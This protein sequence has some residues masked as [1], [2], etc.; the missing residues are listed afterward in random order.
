[1]EKHGDIVPGQTPPEV[2]ACKNKVAAFKQK[3]FPFVAQL[4]AAA[5]QSVTELDSD[6]RKSAADCAAAVLK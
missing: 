6:F 4:N 5:A 3:F 2:T 1:M